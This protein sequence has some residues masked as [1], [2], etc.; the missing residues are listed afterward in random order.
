MSQ[1]TMVM[2]NDMKPK[3]SELGQ[4]VVNLIRGAYNSTFSIRIRFDMRHQ[5]LK[6]Y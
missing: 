1:P 4:R 5:L 3:I 6:W 2:W